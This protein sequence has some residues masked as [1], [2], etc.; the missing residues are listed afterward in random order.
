MAKAK[1]RTINIKPKQADLKRF[2]YLDSEREQA[3]AA[4]AWVGMRELQIATGPGHMAL[5][6]V[7]SGL[8]KAYLRNWAKELLKAA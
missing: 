7:T 6:V 3:A 8:P 5:D 2:A 1:K 4:T